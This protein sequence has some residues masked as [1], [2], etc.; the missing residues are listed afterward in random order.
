MVDVFHIGRIENQR[1]Q[2]ARQ[3]IGVAARDVRSLKEHRSDA[4][5]DLL[6]VEDVDRLNILLVRK[7]VFSTFE[8]E[9]E[10]VIGATRLEIALKSFDR[11][12]RGKKLMLVD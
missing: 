8:I 11:I 6:Y 10:V 1:S 5:G 12:E 3:P 7:L 4:P 9:A 2:L